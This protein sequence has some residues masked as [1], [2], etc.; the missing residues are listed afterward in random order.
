MLVNIFLSKYKIFVKYSHLSTPQSFHKLLPHDKGLSY[1][2]HRSD[3]CHMSSKAKRK[4]VDNTQYSA[5]IVKH[6]LS[7]TNFN[8]L[9]RK[10]NHHTL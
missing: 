6:K 9:R 5:F 2:V 3:I 1:F 8:L 7:L 4:I 10:C